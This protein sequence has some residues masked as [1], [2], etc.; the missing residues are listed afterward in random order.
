MMSLQWYFPNAEEPGALT[1][2]TRLDTIHV[3]PRPD[4]GRRYEDKASRRLKGKGKA[5][6]VHHQAASR[7]SVSLLLFSTTRL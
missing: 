2:V 3:T 5:P 1:R 7:G 4:P 6:D